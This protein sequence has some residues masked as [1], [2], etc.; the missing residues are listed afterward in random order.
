MSRSAVDL[1][2]PGTELRTVLATRDFTVLTMASILVFASGVAAIR[3]YEAF[4]RGQAVMAIAAMP[5]ALLALLL[6]PRPV[7]RGLAVGAA[8]VVC[9]STAF[10]TT[11]SNARISASVFMFIVTGLGVV[12]LPA[13]WQWWW[14]GGMASMWSSITPLAPMPVALDGLTINARWLTLG[15][16][17]CSNAWLVIA[18]RAELERIRLR[19]DI[20]E[21]RLRGVLASVA[22]RE[23]VRVWRESL[24]RIH[25]TV[26]NDI[27]SVL[28][29]SS[30]DWHRLRQQLAQREP[31]APPSRANATLAEVLLTI[32]E[33]QDMADLLDIGPSAAV[34]L[35]EEQAS[36][37][38]AVLLE[39]VRNLRRHSGAT[40]VS[41]FSVAEGSAV[42]IVLRHDGHT[43]TQRG[44]AGIGLGVIVQDALPTLG[45]TL[46]LDADTTTLRMVGGLASTERRDLIHA[47]TWRVILSA[48]AAGNAFGGVLHYALAA[49]AFGPRGVA[50]GLCAGFAGLTAAWASWRRRPVSGRLAL[51]AVGAGIAVPLIAADM[52][53]AC[54]A[55]DLPLAVSTLSSLGAAGV[56]IWAP[57]LRW[58][59]L[60][61][62]NAG[63]MLYLAF[64]ASDGCRHAATPGLIAAVIAPVLAVIVALGLRSSLRRFAE[65][66]ARRREAVR[67]SAAAA[68]ASD[69]GDALHEAVDSASAILQTA[70]TTHGLDADARLALRC[71]DAEIR[72]SIQ[73][74]PGTAGTFALAGRA[75]VRYASQSGVPVR[76]LALRD[77][78]DRRPLPD[79]VL[80][81]MQRLVLGAGDGSS[82][83]Q[84]MTGHGEDTLVVTCSH[85]AALASGVFPGWH[86]RFEDGSADIDMTDPAAPAML[87]VQ[88]RSA[89]PATT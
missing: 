75:V 16:F 67:Q 49:I 72:A 18:W 32:R 48:M 8:T 40:H 27:R 3:G 47:D 22:H 74:D 10:A 42:R 11:T 34:D 64:A 52:T 33:E 73:V 78:G 36:T 85:E 80:E 23:R 20:S 35:D 62:G 63:A 59:W 44:A 82:T 45:A 86:C 5:F 24:T 70:A 71:R 4:P 1:G 58:L 76:V 81:T 61:V 65:S 9:A 29:T 50:L 68:A 7:S 28:D 12:S 46:S 87:M 26:L 55:V 79:E 60:L 89:T 69:F 57:S 43:E 66:D 41:V 25:E 13:R 51:A 53:R 84:A 19:D 56:I 14:V 37:L 83:V 15:Q 88:R 39:L 38:R 21:S 2:D 17:L 30:V 31:L 6:R 54:T 77:S